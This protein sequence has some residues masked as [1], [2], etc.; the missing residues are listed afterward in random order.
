MPEIHI[1]N[2]AT[3]LP[4]AEDPDALSV[5]F[6]DGATDALLAILDM[7]K[8]WHVQITDEH[9]SYPVRIEDVST[10]RHSIYSIVGRRILNDDQDEFADDTELIPLD[11][12]RRVHVW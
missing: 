7:M 3:R 5:S 9:G 12:I 1:D 4:G 8:D 2:P 6:G 11:Q 10:N